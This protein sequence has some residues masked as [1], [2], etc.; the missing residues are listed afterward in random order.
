[1]PL[2][3]A[4]M[5]LNEKS[6]RSGV[7]PYTSTSN[8]TLYFLLG[9][10]ARTGDLTDLGGGVKK[11][12]N[13]LCAAFRE[14]SEES[15]GLLRPNLNDMSEC[16]SL[17]NT[18]MRMSVV[19]MPVASGFLRTITRDFDMARKHTSSASSKEMR[20]LKWVHETEFFILLS[21]KY[22]QQKDG[23]RLSLWFR[24]RSFIGKEYCKTRREITDTLRE[25]AIYRPFFTHVSR[26][27]SR[28]R[29][30]VTG[31]FRDAFQ[32]RRSVSCYV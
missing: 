22:L 16:P 21:N 4:R 18:E 9:V 8:G 2:I 17:M 32:P 11:G 12:E 10:D 29:K 19:F 27:T 25:V 28:G 3:P 30:F 15:C 24:V 23:T 1:M 14:L 7:I 31:R 26:S 20:E 5:L 13:G 6:R